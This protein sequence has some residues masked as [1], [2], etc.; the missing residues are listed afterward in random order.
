MQRI[1]VLQ[2]I[3]QSKNGYKHRS[4]SVYISAD[5][6]D[7]SLLGLEQNKSK[8]SSAQLW[9]LRD[10]DQKFNLQRNVQVGRRNVPE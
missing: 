2:L 10:S 1:L 4:P 6:N 8:N 7:W 5:K 3:K 9:G